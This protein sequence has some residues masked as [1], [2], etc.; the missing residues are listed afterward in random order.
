M[1]TKPIVIAALLVGVSLGQSLPNE[2]TE[3]IIALSAD[4]RNEF[5]TLYLQQSSR[6]C[7][8]AV[9]SMFQGGSDD[10]LDSWSVA[11]TDGESYSVGIAAGPEGT[12]TLMSCDELIAT[13]T[14]LLKLSGSKSRAVGCWKQRSQ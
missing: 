3:R 9:R 4:K 7:D 12:T 8:A 11:C 13:E 5:W 10:G 1:R 2:V 6:K 14:I